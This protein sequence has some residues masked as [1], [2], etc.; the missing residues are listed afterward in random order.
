MTL[1]QN[2]LVE[3]PR[4]ADSMAVTT[5]VGDAFDA[6][7]TVMCGIHE[8][9]RHLRHRRVHAPVQ[10]LHPPL[11][12]TTTKAVDASTVARLSKGP[13]DT[14]TSNTYVARST[15]KCGVYAA[16]GAGVHLHVRRR[17]RGGGDH[18]SYGVGFTGKKTVFTLMNGSFGAGVHGHV[19]YGI[20]EER[21]RRRFHG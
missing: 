18:K 15:V 17:R 16:F 19:V 10:P 12:S 21:E 9:G 5:A 6:E 13:T 3:A 14:V 8:D 20:K 4:I 1:L 11:A 7:S 2:V